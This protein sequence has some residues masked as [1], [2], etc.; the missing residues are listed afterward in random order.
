MTIIDSMKFSLSFK[1]NI[2][3]TQ[4]NFKC[5]L[6]DLFCEATTKIPM[7]S[8]SCTDNFVYLFPI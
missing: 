7:Y 4:F 3:T 8:H 5:I 1:R 6:I 2:L